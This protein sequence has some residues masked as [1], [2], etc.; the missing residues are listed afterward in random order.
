MHIL[1]S[2][3]EFFG[4]QHLRYG[5]A[6]QTI[7]DTFAKVRELLEHEVNFAAEQKTLRNIQDTYRGYRGV[8]LPRLINRYAPQPSRP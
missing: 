5:L 1:Q 8:A 4:E 6:A 7:P 3:S 2:L